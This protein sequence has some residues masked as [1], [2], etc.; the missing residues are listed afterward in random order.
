MGYDLKCNQKNIK[1][2]PGPADYEVTNTGASFVKSSSNYYFASGGLKK[3]E[4]VTPKEELVIT[5][6]GGRP[7]RK[8]QS[9]EK[10]Y[11]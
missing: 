9:R 6:F 10:N 2:A 5:Y 1:I 4:Q 8:S 7:P 11:R 3:P